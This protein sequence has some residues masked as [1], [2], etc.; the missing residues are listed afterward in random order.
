MTVLSPLS[1]ARQ[2]TAGGRLTVAVDGAPADV[3]LQGPDP[4]LYAMAV[5]STGT[6]AFQVPA[7]VRP[8]RYDLTIR[9]Q[10][11]G[12][13]AT[14]SVEVVAAQLFLT[15]AEV[16]AG[17]TIEGTVGGLRGV[18]STLALTF[19]SDDG[20]VPLE[21]LSVG[22]G[23]AWGEAVPFRLALPPA[24][25]SG[26]GWLYIEAPDDGA[27]LARHPLDV[28]DAPDREGGRPS[29]LGQR[30]LSLFSRRSSP[31]PEESGVSAADLQLVYYSHPDDV[32]QWLAKNPGPPAY[33][34]DPIDGCRPLTRPLTAAAAADIR[35]RFLAAVSAASTPLRAVAMFLYLGDLHPLTV[36]RL[37]GLGEGT[38]ARVFLR[39]ERASIFDLALGYGRRLDISRLEGGA[40]Q[41]WERTLRGFC[42]MFASSSPSPPR[43]GSE[44][45]AV[46]DAP[47]PTPGL[48]LFWQGDEPSADLVDVA[49]WLASR[50]LRLVWFTPSEAAHAALEARGASSTLLSP[51]H[52]SAAERK[53]EARASYE[54]HPSTLLDY[55]VN[56]CL[57]S[58]TISQI[59]E[60]LDRL[61][62]VA[63]DGFTHV[64][65][66]ADDMLAHCFEFVARSRGKA[67]LALGADACRGR[68]ASLF[69]LQA[70]EACLGEPVGDVMAPASP[71]GLEAAVRRAAESRAAAAQSR[72][73]MVR[74]RQHTA[75]T[76]RSIRVMFYTG[77]AALER[78]LGANPPDG[79]VYFTAQQIDGHPTLRNLIHVDDERVNAHWERV[80]EALD[81]PVPARRARVFQGLGDAY[82]LLTRHTLAFAEV[83]PHDVVCFCRLDAAHPLH[84]ALETQGPTS[85]HRI[86]DDGRAEV[87]D[88]LVGLLGAGLR[89]VEHSGEVAPEVGEA[90]PAGAERV[91]PRVLFVAHDNEYGLYL[92]PYYPVFDELARRGVPF[93]VIACDTRVAER[94]QARGIPFQTPDLAFD[95]SDDALWRVVRQAW[96][97]APRDAFECLANLSLTATSATEVAKLSRYAS[98]LDLARYSHVFYVPD[99]TAMAYHVQRLAAPLGVRG[100]AMVSASISE[101]LYT[102]PYA[103][104]ADT[105]FCYGRQ[106]ERS[107]R[108][109][110]GDRF[111]IVKAGHP[112]LYRYG[113]PDAA[114]PAAKVVLVAT[115]G[116]DPAEK[117]WMRA[118]LEATAA[119]DT[120][121][122]IKPHP[123][124]RERYLDLEPFLNGHTLLD[125]ATPITEVVGM[126]DVVMTDHSQVGKDAHLLGKHVISVLLERPLI[127][128]RDV[129]SLV[130]CTTVEDALAALRSALGSNAPAV[131]DEGFIADYNWG[132]RA[133]H[134]TV[135]VDCVLAGA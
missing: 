132:N 10:S 17:E 20:R 96:Y 135:V 27:V 88:G 103:Y 11:S 13:E 4:L 41:P 116:Y 53:E 59:G 80:Q 58:S 122:L 8:G 25:R 38:R 30:L 82:R 118:V 35:G 19:C 72:G 131:V 12:A 16:G 99:S 90:R 15:R 3:T 87:F 77:R 67:V 45:G 57:N 98:S 39:L 123:M 111:E 28:S 64:A 21:T 86:D 126:A 66:A 102:N 91:G 124:Y 50:G 79:A 5:T 43:P 54:P 63:F 56:L 9:T 61:D 85:F 36:A 75:R 109:V 113:Q 128:L 18:G 121:V 92:T 134:Y 106:A 62:G 60:V 47:S 33:A 115:S 55:Q 6:V 48:A 125:A 44:R 69:A 83:A 40:L 22:E 68:G 84:L 117:V 114:R 127:D 51:A 23:E 71:R 14:H 2:V 100:L 29:G 31:P 89:S 70:L 101:R 26:Q 1:A 94:L 78:Y 112:Q 34:D 120:R 97:A 42:E 129:P 107:L 52:R 104:L 133:E 105:V 81:D 46:V 73:D 49:E 119:G 37:H 108:Q 32:R 65:R 95:V 76:N 74:V 7:C 24:L 93:D 110:F 130:Y